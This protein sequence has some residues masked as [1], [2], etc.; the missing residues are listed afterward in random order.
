MDVDPAV[1]EVQGQAQLRLV[2]PDDLE[3]LREWKN[4]NKESFFHRDAITPKQQ[5]T[6]YD[7]YVA[8][9]DDYMYIVEAYGESVGC[10]GYRIQCDMIDVYNVIRGR[11][12]VAP[13]VMHK[14]LLALAHEAQRRH[15]DRIVTVKVLANNPAL[16]WYEKCDFYELE[17]CDDYLVLSWRPNTSS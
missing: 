8:R 13:G 5:E 3:L 17:R 14:A 9:R 6:W 1:I 2:T 10:M 11:L 7:A 15:A 4:R 16:K 12:D